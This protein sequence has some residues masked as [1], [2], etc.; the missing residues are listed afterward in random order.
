MAKVLSKS[1]MAMVREVAEP[2]REA[3]V[4]GI[5]T[6]ETED[7]AIVE[8]LIVGEGIATTEITMISRNMENKIKNSEIHLKSHQR[9]NKKNKKIHK[10]INNNKKTKKLTKMT[11]MNLT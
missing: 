5:R 7:V 11:R 8:D 6:I 2:I 3:A 10:P 4:I 1:S 9:R